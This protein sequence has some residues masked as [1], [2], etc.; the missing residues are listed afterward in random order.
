MNKGIIA[1]AVAILV[2]VSLLI[3]AHSQEDMTVVDRS[4][5][6]NP[7]KSSS[8]FKHDA[9]NEKAKIE[10]C[11]ECHHVYKEGKLVEGE[12]SEDKR[13]SDCHQL[14]SNGS[15]PSLIKAFHTNCKGCHKKNKKGP[16]M[17]GECHVRQ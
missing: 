16:I 6:K 11:N 10:E 3:T 15:E 17:C 9:H 8:V 5:F 1:I 7:Q 2:S 4:V 12:S 13:C 14:A